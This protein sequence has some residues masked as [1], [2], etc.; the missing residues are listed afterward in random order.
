MAIIALNHEFIDIIFK[1]LNSLET[2]DLS[3]ESFAKLGALFSDKLVIAALDLVDRGNVIKHI[4]P[5][6]DRSEYE[7]LGTSAKYT[8][9]LDLPVAQVPFYCSCPAFAQ[10]VLST[11]T[12]V[13]CKHV[14]ASLLARHLSLCIDRPVDLDELVEIFSKQLE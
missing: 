6:D 3:D 9:Q 14:L 4:F 1:T 8:V 2:D 7:V 12:H 5:W 13:M 10:L 11:G